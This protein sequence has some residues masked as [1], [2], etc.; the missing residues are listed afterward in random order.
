[1][2]QYFLFWR[3][4]VCIKSVA[5]VEPRATASVLGANCVLVGGVADHVHIAMTLPRTESIS[6]LVES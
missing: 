5:E 1:M 6:R 4:L 3:A 2:E